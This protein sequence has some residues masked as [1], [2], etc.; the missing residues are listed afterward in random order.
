MKRKRIINLSNRNSYKIWLRKL[1]EPE[2]WIL[3]GDQT[4][5]SFC[6]YLVDSDNSILAIDPVG[7]PFI[8]VGSELSGYTVK[9]IEG[10]ILTL[11]RREN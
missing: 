10:N 8:F 4:A 1:K 2:E 11:E 9:K 5:L 7:G 3:E 6:S